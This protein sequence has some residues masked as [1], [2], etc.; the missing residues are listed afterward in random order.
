MILAG[1]MNM[2]EKTMEVLKLDFS[3]VGI[4]GVTILD[5]TYIDDKAIG[6]IFLVAKTLPILYKVDINFSK[7]HARFAYV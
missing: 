7:M 3:K 2:A 1:I 4:A 6:S 5:S